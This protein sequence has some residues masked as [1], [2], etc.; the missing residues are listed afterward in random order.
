MTTLRWEVRSAVRSARHARLPRS[1]QGLALWLMEVPHPS[2]TMARNRIPLPR[3]VRGPERSDAG[4]AAL[5][6]LKPGQ[7]AQ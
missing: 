5:P 4:S 6:E 3:T 1:G 7:R 2:T